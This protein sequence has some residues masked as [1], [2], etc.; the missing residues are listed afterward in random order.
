M[1]AN[2]PR[3][4]YLD[5]MEA[6]QDE[7]NREHFERKYQ[8]LFFWTCQIC[9]TSVVARAKCQCGLYANP[10]MRDIAFK[11]TGNYL[12]D[13]EVAEHLFNKGD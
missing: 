13:E 5:K 11:D 1:G 2:L 4:T 6:K 7:K 10:L 9:G 12:T 8:G 3:E